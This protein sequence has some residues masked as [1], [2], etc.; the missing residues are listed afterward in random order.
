MTVFIILGMQRGDGVFGSLIIKNPRTSEKYSNL[1][2]FDLS[3]HVILLQDWAHQ[4]GV[5]MFAAHHHSIGN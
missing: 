2:D 1:Y 5:S 3:E 4:P